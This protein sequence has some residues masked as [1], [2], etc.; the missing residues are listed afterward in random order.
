MIYPSR[1]YSCIVNLR[2][3]VDLCVCVCVPA[4]SAAFL[5][6][7]AHAQRGLQYLVCVSVCLLPNI[8]LFTRL[9]VPQ[10]ILTLSAADEGR[11]F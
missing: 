4:L 8:S 2:P 11:N 1:Q 10:T 3:A 5:T 6:L 9:F 7:G